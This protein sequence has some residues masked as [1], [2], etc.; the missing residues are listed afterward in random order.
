MNPRKVGRKAL[1]LGRMLGVDPTKP[2]SLIRNIPWYLSDY[3]KLKEQAPESRFEFPLGRPFPCLRE[4][5]D[6]SSGNLGHYFHQDLHVAR[7]IF[8]LA[9]EKH[10][11]VG[12]RVDGFVANVAS[13]R[14]IEVFDI[15]PM[16]T[17]IP[18]VTF[19]QADLMQLD[20]KFVG[21]ADSL[22]CL[23]TIEHFGLGRYGDPIDFDGFDKGLKNLKRILK[24]GGRFHFSTPMGEQRI[25]FNAHRIFSARFLID[26]F[27]P[28]YHIENFSY[29]SDKSAVHV[30]VPLDDPGIE[31][32]FGCRYGCA[33]LE[34]VLKS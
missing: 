20:E 33:I 22:S 24:P 13:F 2:L 6:Q 28:D 18:G 1:K 25:E 34:L 3:R 9:P 26:Y 19:R 4:K 11:D 23:H 10:I 31:N 5:R 14:E 32:N 27:S 7:R 12:S 17:A 21:Y 30:N 16:D 15:R 8:E 29:I